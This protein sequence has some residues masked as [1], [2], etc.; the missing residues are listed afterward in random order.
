MIFYFIL[1]D[2]GC[3]TKTKNPESKDNNISVNDDD[4]VDVDA[5]GIEAKNELLIVM[6]KCTFIDTNDE[7]NNNSNNY[8]NDNDNLTKSKLPETEIT[9]EKVTLE[10]KKTK[11][12]DANGNVNIFEISVQQFEEVAVSIRGRCKL[13]DVQQ[14]LTRLQ[15]HH[16]TFINSLNSNN[17]LKKISLTSFSTLQPLTLSELALSG[18]KVTGKTGDCVLGTLRTMGFV[19]IVK[20]VKP[21]ITLSDQMVLKMIKK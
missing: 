19:K 2:T 3:R 8:D 16:T 1:A 5:D 12:V 15:T 4:D 21:G 13:L 7:N 14:V 17:K 11:K 6:R 20:S 18:L 10:T 9:T